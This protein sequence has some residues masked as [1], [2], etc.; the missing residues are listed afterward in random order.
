M[1][2]KNLFEGL[3]RFLFAFFGGLILAWQNSVWENFVKIG[4][5]RGKIGG[6]GATR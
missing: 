5:M 4:R 1:F 3:W 6:G 2:T